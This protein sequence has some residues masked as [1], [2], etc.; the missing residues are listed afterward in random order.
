M[1]ETLWLCLIAFLAGLIQGMTGFGVMLVALPLMA[2][3]IHIKTAVPLILLLGLVINTILVAQLARYIETQKWLPLFVCSLPGIPAGAYFLKNFA[4]Q[5]L[6]LLV[7][8]VV[9]ATTASAWMGRD[10]PQKELGKR[11]SAAA[12]FAAGFLGGSIGAPGPPV[13][14]YTSFQPWNKHAVKSTM[15]AF[16]TLAGAG[17]GGFYI[18]FGMFTRPVLV[19]FAHCVGPLIGGVLTG[20]ALFE[21]L[22]ETLYQRAI[23]LMLVVLG[24]MMLIRGVGGM[25]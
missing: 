24:V 14:V 16:F 20:I 9:L 6:E 7:G 18:Y 13:I 22:D 19:N 17:I 11:W 1:P 5:W 8:I 12:G 23:Q 3:V 10:R 4:P 15:V 2:L 25:G 21:R